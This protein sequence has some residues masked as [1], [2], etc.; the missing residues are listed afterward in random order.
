MKKVAVLVASK[1]KNLELARSV[2]SKCEEHNLLA[3]LIVLDDLSLS[4]YSTKIQEEEGIS[5][6]VEELKKSLVASDALV[7]ISPEYNGGVAPVLSNAIAW[8]SV[9][10]KDWREAFNEKP[11]LIA[12]HSGGGGSHALMGLRSQLSYIGA[13]VLG[14][15]I[16]T[17]YNKELNIESLDAC[18][19][20][21]S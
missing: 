6:K 8:I 2:V 7:V 16:L 15:Q 9:S 21:L 10:G 17:N 12:T 1:G 13:N 14:R 18:L 19:K 11:C 3:S 20:Q 5:E 4:L